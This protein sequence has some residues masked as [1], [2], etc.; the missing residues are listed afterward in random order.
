MR[1]KLLRA[2]L[3]QDVGSERHLC[4][5]EV[6]VLPDVI[7]RS[8]VLAGRAVSVEQAVQH[9]MRETAVRAVPERKRGRS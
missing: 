6:V 1:V 9:A 2:T 7:G 3:W 4:A 8:L 5:G